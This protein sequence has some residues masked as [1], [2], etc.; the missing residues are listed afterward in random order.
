MAARCLSWSLLRGFCGGGLHARV[1]DCGLLAWFIV[2]LY[3][4]ILDLCI[5]DGEKQASTETLST[6]QPGQLELRP[7]V[8]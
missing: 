7:T 6:S 5:A 8:G 2:A 3:L 1:L 4:L